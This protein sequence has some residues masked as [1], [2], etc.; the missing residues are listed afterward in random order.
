MPRPILNSS[1]D[2]NNCSPQ[3]QQKCLKTT[4]KNVA[5]CTSHGPYFYAVIVMNMSRL[6][7]GKPCKAC[8][9]AA[10]CKKGTCLEVSMCSTAPSSLQSGRKWQTSADHS[11]LARQEW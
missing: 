1:Q 3:Q 5:T 2:L 8:S 6:I 11:V 4:C 10:H 7:Q 9:K